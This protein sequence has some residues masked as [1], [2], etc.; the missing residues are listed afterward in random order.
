MP[1]P[2]MMQ[3]ALWGVEAEDALETTDRFVSLSLAQ[4]DA[5]GA[6][7]RLHDLQLD[8]LRTRFQNGEALALIQG[9]MRLSSHVIAKDPMQFASQLIGRLL[10]HRDNP[11]VLKLIVTLTDGAARPLLV[12]RRQALEP[13][14]TA[15]LLA[16]QGHQTPVNGVS[17]SQ[18]GRRAVSASADE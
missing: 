16:L 6:G 1:V 18:D 8:F 17:V 13:P 2:P 12:P 5:D 11:D 9:A 4:Y 14:G 7:L 10:A 15:L 3:Q